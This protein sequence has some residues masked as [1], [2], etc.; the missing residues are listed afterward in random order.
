MLGSLEE[1][2]AVADHLVI[3]AALTEDTRHIID[4]AAFEL[5]K[6]GVHL[7][8]VGRGAIVDHEALAD[9]LDAG[10]VRRASLDVT[11]P[12]PLPEGHRL[13]ANPNVFVTHHISFSGPEVPSRLI[14]LFVENLVR[15]SSGQPLLSPVDVEIGY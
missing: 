14:D 7:V 15:F 4:K 10:I 3:V 6:P 9:A 12:E 5:V 2:L 11:E 13:L 1:L 8:N